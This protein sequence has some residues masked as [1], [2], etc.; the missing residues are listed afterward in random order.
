MRGGFT[1]HAR[2]RVIYGLFLLL[3]ALMVWLGVSGSLFEG[4]PLFG[5]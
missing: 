5:G 4:L 2:D 3:L 1:R